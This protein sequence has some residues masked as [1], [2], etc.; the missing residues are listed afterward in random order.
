MHK[1]YDSY[2]MQLTH[3]MAFKLTSGS[4][5]S[6]AREIASTGLN[7]RQ[8]QTLWL[9]G[10]FA[11]YPLKTC[12]GKT[13][14]ITHPGRWNRQN[15]PDFRDAELHIDGKCTRGDVEL[16]LRSSDWQS[17][18]HNRDFEYN[19][20]VLHVFLNDDTG[21]I[22]DT[23]HNGHII[24]RLALDALLDV[25]QQALTELIEAALLHEPPEKSV[26]KCQEALGRLDIAFVRQFV[27]AAAR[28]RMKQKVQRVLQSTTHCSIDQALYESLLVALGHKANRALYLILA[29]RVPIKEFWALTDGLTSKQ[30]AECFESTLLHVAGLLRLPD[31]SSNCNGSGL[32]QETFA[33]MEKMEQWWSRTAG[34]YLDR[35]MMPT[36]RWRTGIRPSSFPERRLAGIAHVCAPMAAQGR[37]AEAFAHQFRQSAARHPRTQRAWQREISALSE[38]LHSKNSN[39]WN[40]HYTLADHRLNRPLQLIGRGCARHLL[41]NAILPA[42]LAL[43]LS[44]QDNI[45]EKYAW[46]LYL[47]FPALE[48]NSISRF[49]H[50]RLLSALPPGAVNMR[51][52]F[53][54]Q[55][56]LHIFYDCCQGEPESCQRCALRRQPNDDPQSVIS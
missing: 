42:M 19:N 34:Y 31:G 38:I 39:Y 33:Y 37:L 8:L 41:V 4:R 25:D 23:L 9:G 36:H 18:G 26:G 30:R 52:E 55:G 51:N 22:Y 14:A 11:R 53:T 21:H 28:E 44:T 45:L 6:V 56:L 7:E 32:D 20:V 1:D 43:A 54:Q 24:E 2:K 47:N 48:S 10:F 13:V 27:E 46:E 3:E 50:K 49:M 5:F 29:R 15:G 16:H 40:Y 12:S 35:L 17:H